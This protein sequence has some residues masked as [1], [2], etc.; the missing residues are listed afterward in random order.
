MNPANSFE[1]DLRKRINVKK[2]EVTKKE[3][4]SG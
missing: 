2:K 1:K 3:I 4:T